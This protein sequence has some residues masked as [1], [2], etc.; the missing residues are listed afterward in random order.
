MY[1]QIQRNMENTKID[2]V[3]NRFNSTDLIFRLKWES[4]LKSTTA[5]DK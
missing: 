4:E 3:L 5:G 1:E 2:T